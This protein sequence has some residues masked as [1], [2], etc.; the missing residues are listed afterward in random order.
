MVPAAVLVRQE[1]IYTTGRC[2]KFS[3]EAYLLGRAFQEQLRA[4]WISRAHLLVMKPNRPDGNSA[5]LDLRSLNGTTLNAHPL[6]YGQ[7]PEPASND[8]VVLANV[9]P[10]VFLGRST[11]LEL[12]GSAD[13]WRKELGLPAASKNVLGVVIS[14]T[15]RDY[16]AL[17]S[18]EACIFQDGTISADKGASDRPDVLI[19]LTPVKGRGIRASFGEQ[20]SDVC[21]IFRDNNTI[22]SYQY[23]TS[24][25]DLNESYLVRTTPLEDEDEAA[26]PEGFAEISGSLQVNEDFFE[27]VAC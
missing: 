24:Q 27:V 13:R 5:A 25:L 21:H 8:L 19:K 15:T 11:F 14:G 18:G 23:Y 1:S 20:V 7:F 26:D 12:A 17:R 22:D 10:L 4:R 6:H 16:A 3:G 9:M 2:S